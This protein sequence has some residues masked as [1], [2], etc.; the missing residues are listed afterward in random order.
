LVLISVLEVVGNIVGGSYKAIEDITVLWVVIKV[1]LSSSE[2]LELLNG[3][4]V[5]GDLWESERLFVDI[6]SVDLQWHFFVKIS[7]NNLF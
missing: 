1:L 5:L 7:F 2:R 6:K 4:I 3:V